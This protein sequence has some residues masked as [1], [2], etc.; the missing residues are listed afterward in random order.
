MVALLLAILQLVPASSA[1]ASAPAEPSPLSRWEVSGALAGPS[2]ATARAAR[3]RTRRWVNGV[4][5]TEYWPV[6]ERWFKGR[7]L[8]APG[9]DR[10]ARVDWLYSARG[11]SMEGDGIGLDGR[12]YHIEDLGAA[13]WIN[14]RGRGTSP[15]DGEWS[16]G[17]PWW[18]NAR[19]WLNRAGRPTFPLGRGGWYRGSPR[20]YVPNKGITFAP[21]PS[22][23]LTYWKSV[24]VDPDVIPLGSRIYIPAYEDV[25]GGWFTA[26][27]VGGAI[28][29]KH[30]DVFRPPPGERFGD[31]R[32]LEGQRVLVVPPAAR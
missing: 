25:N 22:R 21:G 24:A 10:P 13:G 29:R 9:L 2:A 6:P 8:N 11:V 17:P 27:D 31:G 4:R 26:A 15:D 1:A 28:D 30:I 14:K 19:I 5:V 7:R 16:N 3:I 23:E 18:R 12:R 32:N 20:R